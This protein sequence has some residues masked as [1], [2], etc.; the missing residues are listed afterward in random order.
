MNLTKTLLGKIAVALTFTGAMS[1]AGQ[2]SA[3]CMATL[4]GSNEV[5]QTL[6]AGQSIDAG[7]VTSTI[8]DTNADSIGDTL[9]I[10]Y[11]TTNGWELNE[12]HLWVGDDL[13]NMPQTRKG[14]PKLGNFPYNSGDITGSTSYNV[15]ISL[16]VLGFSCP[17]DDKDFLV[18]AHAALQKPDGNGGYQTETG[19]GNG[20]RI[21]EKGNWATYFSVTLSCSCDDDNGGNTGNHTCETAFAYLPSANMCFLDIDENGD[22]SGDFNRWGWSNG[23]LTAGSYT[24]DIYAGAGRCDINKGTHVGHLT[25]D[26]DGSTATVTYNTT[27]GF[28]MNETHLYVGND[29]LAKDVNGENTVAPGQYPTIHEGLDGSSSDTYILDASGNIHV[30]AHGVVCG[31]Y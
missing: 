22:G 29:I 10:T 30:V 8:I 12:T 16:N 27:N 13:Q 7:T 31:A 17:M 25:V 3:A 18:A 19:W 24:M 4:D 20:D 5:V 6:Y 23:E 14:S 2:A 26:Y 15:Q 11:N 1:V 9:S 28:T 21:V